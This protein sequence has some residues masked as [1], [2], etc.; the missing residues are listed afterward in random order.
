MS[1]F[2]FLARFIDD[3]RFGE[4]ASRF[5]GHPQDCDPILT[6]RVFLLATPLPRTD[7]SEVFAPPQPLF[8]YAIVLNAP[9]ITRAA[10]NDGSRRITFI[11]NHNLLFCRLS[12][13]LVISSNYTGIIKGLCFWEL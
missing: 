1:F 4:I 13:A 3:R 2:V 10:G 7:S 5:G 8:W 6:T 12:P 9:H 11:A